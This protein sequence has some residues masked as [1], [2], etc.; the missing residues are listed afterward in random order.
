MYVNSHAI[1]ALFQHATL[2]EL[3]HKSKAQITYSSLYRNVHVCILP[4][5]PPPCPI[6]GSSQRVT[7]QP[8]CSTHAPPDLRGARRGLIKWRSRRTGSAHAPS[9]REHSSPCLD[10]CV[11]AHQR[12]GECACERRLPKSVNHHF[13][14]RFLPAPSSR[15]TRRPRALPRLLGGR[16]H[17]Q[18]G[19][20]LLLPIDGLALLPL[21]EFG[22]RRNLLLAL[23]PGLRLLTD[24]SGR[25]HVGLCAL[26]VVQ[27]RHLVGGIVREGALGRRPRVHSAGPL[28]LRKLGRTL[29]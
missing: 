13:S 27:T 6:G 9:H 22:D 29:R 12:V 2:A 24:G 21:L 10:P 14:E 26:V 17:R 5:L 28:V 11:P 3:V 20:L 4:S 8:Q 23:R 15:T 25:G 18:Q 1:L 16:C 7:H 19:L